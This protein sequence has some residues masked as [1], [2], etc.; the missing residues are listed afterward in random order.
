MSDFVFNVAAGSVI[1][2]AK[3]PNAND[4]LILIPL[5]Y[6][7]LETDAV[8]RDKATFADVVSGATNEQT[9]VGRQT[10]TSVTTTVNNTLDRVEADCANPSYATP[11]GNR[12]GAFVLCYDPDTTT[13]TDADLIPLCKYGVDWTPDGNPAAVNIADFFRAASAT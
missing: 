12:I 11:S 4:A 13:G 9:T 2:Y 8:L 1:G 3:L 6:A 10:L 7:G 5:E